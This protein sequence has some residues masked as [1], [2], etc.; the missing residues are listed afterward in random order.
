ML[1][2]REHEIKIQIN[3]STYG[4]RIERGMIKQ[5]ISK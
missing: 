2:G 5:G 4:I 3:I 1:K